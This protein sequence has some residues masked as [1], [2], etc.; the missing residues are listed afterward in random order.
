MCEP[1]E[2]RGQ[3]ES[4]SASDAALQKILQPSAKKQLL[5]DR[6]KEEREDQ[7]FEGMQWLRPR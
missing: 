2:N 5:G 6:N 3:H 1:E 4:C 7:C